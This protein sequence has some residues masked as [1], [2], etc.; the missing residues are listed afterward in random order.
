MGGEAG[1]VIGIVLALIGVLIYV[2]ATKK[3]DR[4]D[5][6]RPDSDW[7]D[8]GKETDKDDPDYR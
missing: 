8:S 1:V 6:S 7:P 5:V 2:K 3:S 4:V